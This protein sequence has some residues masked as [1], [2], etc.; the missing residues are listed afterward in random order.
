MREGPDIIVAFLLIL[1]WSLIA[2]C[3]VGALLW[4]AV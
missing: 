3:V 1:C 2:L 4:I